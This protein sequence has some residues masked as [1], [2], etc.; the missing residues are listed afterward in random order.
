[1]GSRPGAG[2]NTAWEGR[3]A[4]LRAALPRSAR[5]AGSSQGCAVQVEPWA[6]RPACHAASYS[7]AFALSGTVLRV[8][9][10][11]VG[12]VII[13]FTLSPT[14]LFVVLLLAPALIVVAIVFG[15]PL[16][17]VST[18]VQDTI[19]R[20]TTGACRDNKLIGAMTIQHRVFFAV[21]NIAIAL[22]LC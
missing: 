3:G 19:A 8:R 22:T 4:P 2:S 20:S 11:L 9:R 5:A 12:S 15:R 16:E 21:E 7:A 1:M 14:L 10:G 18:Q 13:L 6:G 17:R